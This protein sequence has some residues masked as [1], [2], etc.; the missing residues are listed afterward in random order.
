MIKRDLGVFLGNGGH[1]DGHLER[2]ER[3]VKKG[4]PLAYLTNFQILRI[5]LFFLG[6][7]LVELKRLSRE[8]DS[9]TLLLLVY[10]NFQIF[11]I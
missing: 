5:I 9:F 6:F 1:I 8:S 2:R 4:L 11:I 3:K 10:D 7:T